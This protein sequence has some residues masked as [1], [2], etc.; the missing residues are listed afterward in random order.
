MKLTGSLSGE[1]TIA[2]RGGER[3]YGEGAG[4]RRRWEGAGRGAW[5]ISSPSFESRC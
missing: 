5:A 2:E 1:K 3:K 4:V